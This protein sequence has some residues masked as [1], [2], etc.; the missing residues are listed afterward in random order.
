M[1]MKVG[2]V[3]SY[4]DS[5]LPYDTRT[6]LSFLQTRAPDAPTGAR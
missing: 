1:A 6:A 2:Q 4:I 5:T 3:L